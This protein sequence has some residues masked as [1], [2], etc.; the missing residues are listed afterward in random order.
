M[1][2]QEATAMLKDYLKKYGL[3]LKGWKIALDNARF[4]LG[5]TNFKDKTISLSRHMIRYNEDAIIENCIKHEVAHALVGPTKPLHGKM[6]KK[7]ALAIGGD[8]RATLRDAVAGTKWHAQCEGCSKVY[9]RQRK[10]AKFLYYCTACGKESGWQ[11]GELTWQLRQ[12][13]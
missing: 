8:G 13:G 10:P 3:D 2:E 9:Y 6:W 11:K 7:V 1:T 12:S 5:I 4:R